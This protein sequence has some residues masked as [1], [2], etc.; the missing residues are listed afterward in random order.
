ELSFAAN[1]DDKFYGQLT[2][3]SGGDAGF[4]IEEAFIDTTALP[5][6]FSLRAGR[7]F[8]NIGY[9]NSHHSHTDNFVDR[10]LAYQAFLGNQYGDD[11]VQLRFVAPTDLYLELGGEL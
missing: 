3:T 8:S 2:M 7:F 5:D 1:I 6:G 4:E 11:G 10:P 9:L